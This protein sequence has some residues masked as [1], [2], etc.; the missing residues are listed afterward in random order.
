MAPISSFPIQPLASSV[1]T[2]CWAHLGG[3]VHDN[4]NTI[5]H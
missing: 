1:H 5:A 3:T 2:L 4:K